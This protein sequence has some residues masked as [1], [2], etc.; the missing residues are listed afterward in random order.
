M[1]NKT[2]KELIEQMI[3]FINTSIRNKRNIFIEYD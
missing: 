2:S 1:L 3:S